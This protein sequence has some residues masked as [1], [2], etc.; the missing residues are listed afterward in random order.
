MNATRQSGRKEGGQWLRRLDYAIGIP[1]LWI[2]AAFRRKRSLP[3][4]VR[5]IAVIKADGMGDLVLLTALFKDLKVAYPK[6][7]LSLWCGG[8]VQALAGELAILDEVCPID[9]LRPWRGWQSLR[10]WQPDI[11]LNTGQWSRSEAL[12]AGLGGGKYTVGFDTPGQN[13]HALY[14]A[15]VLH[16][17]DRHE[18]ENFRDL[19]TPLDISALARPQ[20]ILRHET[21]CSLVQRRP[22]FAFH[23]WPS[24]VSHVGLKQWPESS[25]AALARYYSDKGYNIVVTGGP[26]DHSE[27]ERWLQSHQLAGQVVNAAGIPMSE[28]I[29]LLRHATAVISVNTG[30]M[31]LAAALEVPTVAL[32]GPT[33]PLRWGPI[34]KKTAQCSV[35]QPHGGYLNLGFEFP[36]DAFSRPG[37]ETIE[38]EEIIECVEKLLTATET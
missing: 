1:A 37:I 19:L 30:V 4:N 23:L 33:N 27:N 22:Y 35:A 38:I 34:G 7:V 15:V 25:W 17:A 2:L 13:H 9:F 10:R 24:G 26:Q 20:M 28:T 29:Q 14:D 12:L 18:V 31:H 21:P 6:S 32:N 3:S 11:V 5:R 8:S 36:I 16:R